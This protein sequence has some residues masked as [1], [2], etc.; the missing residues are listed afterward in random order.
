MK[1][2]LKQTNKTKSEQAK[3]RNIKEVLTATLAE[4][5]SLSK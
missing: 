2:H 5:M 1:K 4:S 3:Q